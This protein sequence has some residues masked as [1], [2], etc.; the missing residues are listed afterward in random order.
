[1]RCGRC[2]ADRRL[3]KRGPRDYDSAHDPA[4][5]PPRPRIPLLADFDRPLRPAAV[6]RR[7]AGAFPPGLRRGAGRASR[8]DRRNRRRRRSRPS[9]T[10]S[11]RWNEAAARSSAWPTSSSCSPAPTPATRSRR[12]SATCRRCL[13]RH[14]NALYLDRAL[15]ARIADLY[16][17]RDTLGLTAEQARVLDRYHTR[18]VRAGAALDKA[19]QDKL[20]D[21]QRAARQPRHAVRPERAR[22]REVLCDDP[23]RERSRRPAGL[24][25]RRRARG[26]RGARP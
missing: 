10:P 18:F 25:P 20:A 9:P 7:R 26:G 3:A 23:G 4:R 15:Y 22:R 17:R 1:M 21:N 12:S 14:S 11:R 19:Q 16:A 13:A 2:A 8:R 24:R 6:R 5:L